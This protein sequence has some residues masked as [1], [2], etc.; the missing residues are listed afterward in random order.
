MKEMN[1]SHTSEGGPA[2]GEGRK[3]LLDGLRVVLVSVK[4]PGNLG[5]V[6]RVMKN[7][8]FSDLRLVA[9]RA[10][11]NKE[12][13]QL[14]LEGSDVL[15]G[16]RLHPTL[17]SAVSDCGLVAGTT[18]RKGVLR[19]N[20]LSLEEAGP[21]LRTVVQVNPVALV[22]GAEDYG[23]TNED[24]ALCHWVIG[25][26]TGS[27]YESFNLSHAVAIVLYHL[28]RSLLFTDDP[29]RRLA[30]AVDLEHTFSDIERFLVETGFIHEKDPKRMM[31]VIR[32]FLHR[33]ALSE[34]EARIIRGILRQ[35]RWRIQNPEA[36]LTQRDLHQSLKRKRKKE[37]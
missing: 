15:D 7:T 31:T 32:Q 18:R 37:G 22:F 36:E 33:A 29:P 8:G 30:G 3:N 20:V 5:M 24:L 14:A 4:F 17:L 27:D 6:A 19:R 2:A 16:A 26:H 10:E 11:L 23:L 34:R 1:L 21:M 35:A 28:N 13:Y 12:A 9:P 25:L